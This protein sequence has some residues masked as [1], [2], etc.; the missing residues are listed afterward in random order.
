[1][2]Y[3]WM[4]KIQDEYLKKGLEMA[5]F[6]CNQFNNQEP[7]TNKEIIDFIRTKYGVK[8]PIMVKADVNGDNTQPVFRKLRDDSELGGS[9]IPW[10]F[11]KFLLDGQG[12][13]IKYYHP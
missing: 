12:N 13:L 5:L 9:P 4:A 10:N 1:M 3:S 6:P 8:Y 2:N 11:S 7:G